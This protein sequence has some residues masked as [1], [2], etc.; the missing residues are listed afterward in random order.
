MYIEDSGLDRAIYIIQHQPDGNTDSYW[1]LNGDMTVLGFGR[2]DLNTYLSATPNVFTVGL[3]DGASFDN[4]E[5]IIES[6][7]QPLGVAAGI[8]ETIPAEASY[9]AWA[10]DEFGSVNVDTPGLEATLWGMESDP[11]GDGINNALEQITALDPL[12]SDALGAFQ[13]EAAAGGFVFHYRLSKATHGWQVSPQFS[14]D[15]VDW[16]NLPGAP[17][18]HADLGDA[19]IWEIALPDTDE[20]IFARLRATP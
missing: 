2:L 16:T 17:S 18:L 9:E 1:Q 12:V 14:E 3:A 5:R 19:Q 10:R 11:D 6:A 4:M 8:A 7:Y 15:F 13:I 20:R